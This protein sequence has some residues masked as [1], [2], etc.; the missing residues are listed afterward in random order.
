[1]ED[2]S[3]LYNVNNIIVKRGLED[4]YIQFS[5]KLN[6]Y[7]KEKY[8]KYYIGLQLYQNKLDPSLFYVIAAYYDVCG[9]DVAAVEIGNNISEIY[10]DV[11]G[12]KVERISV[13]RFLDYTRI[14]PPQKY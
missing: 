14:S 5:K 3:P 6:K 11:W 13:F 12:D 7:L 1:M 10:E 4:K 2:F 9:I 8:P